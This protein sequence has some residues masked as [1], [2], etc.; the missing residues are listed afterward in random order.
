[1]LVLIFVWVP[2][3]CV[4]LYH[5]FI[6]DPDDDPYLLVELLIV[7][8]SLQGIL[9]AVVYIWGYRPF[10]YWI[11]RKLGMKMKYESNDESDE[12]LSLLSHRAVM[13]E[14]TLQ[15]ALRGS[16]LKQQQDL[17]GSGAGESRYRIESGERAVR[18]GKENDVRVI[19]IPEKYDDDEESPNDG[20]VPTSTLGT[21]KKKSIKGIL[22][23]GLRHMMGYE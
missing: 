14:S 21:K 22:A 9:N 13:N 4:N 11:K 1:M 8:T 5:T 10:R 20:D 2:S 6:I 7:L 23:R 3:I 19:V 16:D 12:T 17:T 18:F 15:S